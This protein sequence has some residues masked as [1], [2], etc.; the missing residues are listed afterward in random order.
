MRLVSTADLK[1]RTNEVLRTALAGEP[2]VITRHGRPI[3]SLARLAEGDLG[4]LA[5]AG[6][7]PSADPAR[8]GVRPRR[9]GRPAPRT[10]GS[11]GYAAFSLPIGTYYVAFGP[12]GPAFAR[13]A[14]SADAF[15]R[16]AARYLGAPVRRQPPPRWLAEA[17]TAAVR[18]HEAFRG[19]VDLARVGPFEREV[20]EVLRR[21]PSGQVR[22]Y[23]EVARALGQP[24][25]AR[26]VGLACARNPLPLLI[27]CHRVIR[28]D[29]GLGG[30]SL[31]GGAALKRRL[32]RNEGALAS[33]VDE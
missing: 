25:A 26:A 8:R 28:S 20:L 16:D 24:G 14:V 2:V 6:A 27:P 9:H 7:V 30:Y 17:I 4:T 10:A 12:Q 22:T 23:R 11:Y 13:I 33:L 5:A 3:A 1:N 19:P 32:L 21:I 31:R 18:R 29:G 15:E